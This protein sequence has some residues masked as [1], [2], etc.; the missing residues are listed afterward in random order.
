MTQRERVLASSLIGI[1]ALGGGALLVQMTFLGPLRQ[2]NTEIAALD[3]EIRKKEEELKTDEA[4][5]DRAMKLSPRLSQ[6]K[7]LSLPA[8]KDTRPE[9]VLQH[10]K[11]L[12]VDYEA[13]LYA[14]LQRNGFAP[15]TIAVS[16]R[17]LE[18]PRTGQN[19]AKGPPPVVRT[20]PFTVQ[21]QVSLDGLVKMLEEFH[22]AS[23]LQQVRA[24][25]VQKPQDRNAARGSLDVNMTI[26]ALM[27]A[28]A[29]K[30]E[31]LMPASSS[32]SR[33]HVLAEAARS[34][35]DLAAHNIFNGS[36][37][38]TPRVQAQTEDARDVLSFIKLT[39]VSNNN[40]RRWEA[41][42]N[43][44]AKK[45]GLSRLRTSAGFNEFSFSDRYEN[46]L[47]KGLIVRI[48]DSGVLFKANGRFYHIGRGDNLYDVMKEQ[49]TAPAPAAGAAIGP[50][51]EAPW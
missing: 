38:T 14:L 9:E 16:S 42:L 44:Q 51:W 50:A 7:Q 4:A 46:V 6:W 8:T 13:Y 43:D 5:I 17:P 49:A 35:A 36:A 30:R 32:T 1:V 29:E 2:L 21:G 39:I 40:G 47:V 26:E 33:P 24:I 23:L 20:L 41:W 28:G 12:Q 48:D 34:Y 37:P 11:T 27:V 22:R 19:A 31:E 10:L 3:E 45:D 15:G 18:A 25:N